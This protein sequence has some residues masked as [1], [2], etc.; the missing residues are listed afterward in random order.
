LRIYL[1]CLS[2]HAQDSGQKAEATDHARIHDVLRRCS[3]LALERERAAFDARTLEQDLARLLLGGNVEQHRPV[4]DLP[5][6]RSALAGAYSAAACCAAT[7]CWQGTPVRHTPRHTPGHTPA[8][9][10]MLRQAC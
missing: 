7:P 10:I 6:A 9:L 8:T 5:L 1:P 4:L 2:A 3:I